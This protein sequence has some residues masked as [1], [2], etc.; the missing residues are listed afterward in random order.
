VAGRQGHGVPAH[1]WTKFDGGK[2]RKL[3][4]AY[5]IWAFECPKDPF[6][7]SPIGVCN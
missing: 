4:S 1:P 7:D 3:H 5:E 2:R 6:H